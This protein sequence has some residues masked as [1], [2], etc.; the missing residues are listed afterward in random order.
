M[1]LRNG[2]VVFQFSISVILIICTIIVNSQMRYMT[3]DQLGFTKDHVIIIQ[4][5][6]LLADKTKAFKNELL[7]IPGVEKISGAS[8]L[9]GVQNFFGVSWF[10]QGATVPM[11]GRGIFT[12]NEHAET[13]G[14][15]IKEGRYFSKDFPTDSLAIVLNERA[16]MEL[17]LEKAVGARLTSP[18]QFFNG[19]DGTP[20]TYTV[21]GVVKD[22]HYQ[23][24]HKPITPLVF[25][26][27]T[28]FNDVLGMTAVRVKAGNFKDAVQSIEN[29][30]KEF[31]KDRPFQYAFLDK[32]VEEQYLAE[33]TSQKIF[34]FFS[35]L[36]IFI[37]CIGLLGLAAYATQQ[38]M[39]EISIRKVL[40]A[41]AGNIVQMLSKD[42]MK[43][44]LVAALIA[45][46]VAW[47]FMH[48]W[49]EDF[50]YRIN[51]SLWVFALA[52]FLAVLIALLTISFQAIKAAVSNT[53]R[54]L[55]SE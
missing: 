18:E 54:T 40:G 45:F 46:P 16:V 5:T 25:T 36:A 37:A 31:V 51:I 38:R 39:R 8:S 24:L 42:F 41:S 6:D 2:L 32:T 52:G 22:F 19:Q 23:S 47:F 15:Q 10:K 55:R 44:V 11:V 27:A 30:W 34:S 9:P 26:N 14:L 35:S 12:D 21:I 20:Y 53:V 29:K 43:L 4:R 33:A 48:K 50:A 1:L 13:L 17:G 3:S 28:R 49:L 7:K